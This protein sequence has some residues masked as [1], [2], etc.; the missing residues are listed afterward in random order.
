MS[1]SE[2]LFAF[3][4]S[5]L[6]SLDTVSHFAALTAPQDKRQALMA[7]YAFHVTIRRIATQVSSPEMGEIRLQ[8]WRDVILDTQSS[9]ESGCGLANIGPLAGA[10]KQIQKQYQLPCDQLEA[11]V[12]AH[13]FDLASSPMPDEES[14]DIYSKSTTGM[15]LALASRILNDGQSTDR[16]AGLFVTA[17]KAI[18]LTEHLRVWPQT[19]KAKQLFLPLDAFQ[20][21]GLSA[22]DLYAL[23]HPDQSAEAIIALCHKAASLHEEAM[24]GLKKLKAKN[25]AHLAPAFLALAPVPMIL[26]MRQKRPHDPIEISNW[27]SYWH[28][29]RMAAKF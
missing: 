23:E 21:H 10:L 20:E 25:N 11:I 1:G 8:W 29:W 15:R 26:K 9:F 16:L 2:D 14:Y 4:Q 6:K 27:R 19:T 22:H 7:L 17:G 18:S 24:A 12:D 5:E 3:C 13:A 28:I